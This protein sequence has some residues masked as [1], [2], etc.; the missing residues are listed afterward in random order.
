MPD[1]RR[2][3]ELLLATRFDFDWLPAG[4]IRT[5]SGLAPT[6]RVPCPA[7]ASGDRPGWVPERRNGVVKR[8][9]PCTT[10]GGREA[11]ETAK[12]K[13]GRGFIAVDPMDSEQR[14]VGSTDTHAT[15]RPRKRV[16][17]DACAGEGATA[18]GR[19][20]RCD[21]SGWRDLH[22]FDLHLDL[23][24]SGE[25]DALT[26]AIVRRDKAGSYHELDLALAGISRHVNKPLRFAALTVNADRARRL[27][28]QVY[29]TKTV[30]LM[31][32]SAFDQALVELA[33]AYLDMRMP[34]PIRVPADVVANRKILQHR[35]RW[36]KGTALTRIERERRNK[37]IRKLARDGRAYQWIAAE[38]GLS[39]RQLREII[40]G[41]TEAA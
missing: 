17:C 1:R 25:L 37:E 14:A 9:L 39:D 33:M 18:K 32:L 6:R 40:N 4:A 35:P 26:A 2:Q 7:C 28:D 13:R 12:A 41:R 10:C 36:P 3:I 38:F 19:C 16:R 8:W 22:Q 34:D 29:L 24:E 21:G 30:T 23:H 31:G 11:T 5:T 27:L 15:A 20:A